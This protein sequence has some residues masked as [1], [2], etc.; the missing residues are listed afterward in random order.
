MSFNK[1]NKQKPSEPSL[2]NSDLINLKEY[3]KNIELLFNTIGLRVFDDLIEDKSKEDIFICKDSLGSDAKGIYS[4]KGFVIL[5]G[6]KINS[7]LSKSLGS[8]TL[9]EKLNEEK[10]I[11]LKDGIYVLKEDIKV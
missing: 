4:D 10:K 8:N 7:Q 5:K 1:E 6:A 2:A 11:A 3:A 9:L